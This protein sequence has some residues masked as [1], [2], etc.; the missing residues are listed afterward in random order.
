MNLKTR[1]GRT[2]LVGVFLLGCAWF[3]PLQVKADGYAMEKEDALALNLDIAQGL[4]FN[5]NAPYR[6]S[7]KLTPEWETGD[8]GFGVLGDVRY[9]NPGWDLGPGVTVDYDFY[10]FLTNTGFKLS[11]DAVYW[12]AANNFTVECGVVGEASGIIRIGV[13]AGHDFLNN[14]ISLMVSAGCD[15]MT[16]FN[17]TP[18]P[19]DAN[20]NQSVTATYDPDAVQAHSA[21]ARTRKYALVLSGG[22]S[23]GAWTVG[24]LQ[25]LL[26]YLKK[27]DIQLT[28]VCGTS[29]GSLIAPMMATDNPATLENNLAE[30]V[31]IYTHTTTQDIFELN[32]PAD[33]IKTDAGFNSQPLQRTI[34][35]WMKTRADY[36]IN[37]PNVRLIITTACMQNYKAVNYFTGEGELKTDDPM[38]VL[39]NEEPIQGHSRWNSVKDPRLEASRI[40]DS[41]TLMRAMLASSVDPVL[42]PLVKIPQGPS[43][44]YQYADGGAADFTPFEIAFANGADEVYSVTLS[45]VFPDAETAQYEDLFGTLQQTIDVLANRVD[46]A[47]TQEAENYVDAWN[48]AHKTEKSR[49]KYLWQIRPESK[50]KGDPNVFDPTQMT[51]WMNEGKKR[52]DEMIAKW[53]NIGKEQY[54]NLKWDDKDK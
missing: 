8:W 54:Q 12:P 6:F 11:A 36:I 50:I 1:V 35:G 23:T 4:G 34:A 30:C 44:S 7:G 17:L 47:D 41:D 48:L 26:P 45:P 40:K 14:D 42:F 39:A 3:L 27:K 32:S 49:M 18:H 33:M 37:N 51:E 5:L 28:I 52:A 21:P 46:V 53:E 25:E 31:S 22:G 29:T 9:T 16:V 38:K 15:L 20:F 43:A 19:R 13:L 2:W 24:A 10:K